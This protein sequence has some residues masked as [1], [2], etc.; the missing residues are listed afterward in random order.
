MPVGHTDSVDGT[1]T[2]VKDKK[3]KQSDKKYYD[4]K[5]TVAECLLDLAILI[6]NIFMLKA[7]V[8]TGP[9]NEYFETLVVL[10]SVSVFCQICVGLLLLVI[11]IGESRDSGNKVWLHRFNHV[12]VAFIMLIA[13]LNIV[14][15]TIGIELNSGDDSKY[16]RTLGN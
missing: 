2:K 8:D 4:V 16:N 14:I 7:V 12:N 1:T 10:I 5:K 3:T 15:G 13:I 11:G 6:V 9:K